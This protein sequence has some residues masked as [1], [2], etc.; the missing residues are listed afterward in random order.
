VTDHLHRWLLTVVTLL[1]TSCSDGADPQAADR[2]LLLGGNLFA[3]GDRCARLL[4][5][6]AS[7][8][9]VLGPA[10]FELL[11]L[12][13]ATPAELAQA[14]HDAP[15]AR[16]VVA[17]VGDLTLLTG[18]DTNA[19][20]PPHKLLTS[21]GF[22]RAALEEALGEIRSIARSRGML[23]V[24]ATHPLGRQGRIEVPEL[25]EVADVVREGDA[26]LDLSTAFALIEQ[27]LLFSNGI[28][29]LDDYGHDAFA[30]ALFHSLLEDQPPLPPRNDAE[31]AA[32]AEIS[33]LLAWAEGNDTRFRRAARE[34]LSEPAIGADQATR[35]AAIANLMQGIIQPTRRRWTLIEPS[36]EGAV[37]GL[38]V[39]RMLTLGKPG[40]TAAD[41]VEQGLIEI[42]SAIGRADAGVLELADNLVAAAPHR[43][44]T[45]LAL[46]LAARITLGRRG[47]PLR[48][49]RHLAI[50]TTESMSQKR[51][52]QLMTA[53]PDCLGALP[54]LLQ[55]ESVF[56][57]QLPAGPALHSA[58]R[59]SRLGLHSQAGALLDRAT[60]QLVVPDNWSTERKRIEALADG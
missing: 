46:E 15:A 1:A 54:A 11:A 57:S 38:A 21:R 12:P 55:L 39:G 59:S 56:R 44:S 7:A 29:E 23:C 58:R 43:A 2:V 24:V 3:G 9:G 17:V 33:A 4:D 31:A 50:Y 30:S 35:H 48:A 14:L 47:V 34:I 37:P 42:L 16:A 22:D 32:R 18:I 8:S 25:L 60:H 26:I 28:D 41:T 20:F 36:A 53:W 6:M 5:E 40:L 51:W 10:F 13:G 52:E 49:L 27:E 19:E 45:W